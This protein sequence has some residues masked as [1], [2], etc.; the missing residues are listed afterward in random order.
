MK[1]PSGPQRIMIEDEASHYRP[2]SLNRAGDASPTSANDIENQGGM[3]VSLLG[4]KR[5]RENDAVDD[6]DT[7]MRQAK[8]F[9]NQEIV[10]DKVRMVHN[11]LD[12]G[13]ITA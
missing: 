10:H 5:M 12:S 7:I 2:R 13:V 6:N 9:K 3:A 11:Q 4:R 8:R 1:K